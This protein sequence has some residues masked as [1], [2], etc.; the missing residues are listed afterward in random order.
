MPEGILEDQGLEQVEVATLGMNEDDF[1]GVVRS[2][3]E[4]AER[5]IDDYIAPDRAK[6]TEAFQ[7][8]DYGDEEAGRSQFVDSTLR[9]TVNAMMPSLMRIFFS[10]D[11]VVEFV[12]KQ[13]E[14]VPFAEQMTEYV[15]HIITSENNGWEVLSTAIKESLIR[16]CGFIKYY[17]D[18]KEKSEG[19]SY[20][21]LDDETLASLL[22]DQ[23]LEIVTLDSYPLENAPP[24]IPPEQVP[25]S[26]DVTVKRNTTEGRIYLEAVPPEEVLY[27]RRAKGFHDDSL[28]IIAQ[29]KEVTVSD[30]VALGYDA[31]EFEDLAGTNHPMDLKEEFYTRRPEVNNA[32]AQS[33]DHEPA[34]KRILYTEVYI[35]VDFEETG[36]RSWRRVCLVGDKY[37]RILMNVPVNDH[38]FVNLVPFPEPFD[39]SGSSL[40]H[41]L[42]DVQRTKTNILRAM[43]DSLSLSVHPRMAFVDGQVS[44]SDLMNSEIGALIRMRS[45]GAVQPLSVPYTGQQ[46]EGVLSYFTKLTENRT[47]V[48]EASQGLHPEVMQSAHRSA[49]SQVVQGTMQKVE[50]IARTYAEGAFKQLYKGILKLVI[51]HQDKVKMFKLRNEWIPIDPK[52]WNSN[53]DVSCNVALGAGD[54]NYKLQTLM[55][56]AGKQEQILTTIGP[57]NPLVNVQQYYN[58]LAKVVELSGH[59][60]PSQFFSDPRFYQPKQ[61]EPPKPTPEEMLAQVQMQQIQAQVAIEQAKLALEENKAQT[62]AQFKVAELEVDSQLKMQELNAKYNQSIDTTQLRGILDTQREQ[63]RQQGLLEQARINKKGESN[64]G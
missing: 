29:R 14:D 57:D 13:P 25:M 64:E 50:M 38:P 10:S 2:R 27:N 41:Y 5:F 21:G 36:L 22:T 58:T 24:D 61:K 32:Q 51:A 20:T 12:P 16:G 3:L 55:Q 56:L 44:V 49:I 53:F 54:E 8:R 11:R 17:Y 19:Y 28:D 52:V 30:L 48:T 9:D 39:V 35:K 6:A 33:E 60:D 7:S 42:R 15:R 59:K 26:H 34:G 1:L 62:E 43:L 47:G 18:E 4:D 31:S 40:Y 45:P 37:E 23:G 63:I 46:A